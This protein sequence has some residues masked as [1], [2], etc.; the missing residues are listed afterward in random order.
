VTWSIGV[1]PHEDEPRLLKDVE[2]ETV[3]DN[4]D[5]GYI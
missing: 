1:L 4:T 5:I 3:R 2:D